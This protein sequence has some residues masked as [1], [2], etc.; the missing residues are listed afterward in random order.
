MPDIQ[1]IPTTQY[2][3]PRI[4]PHL[5]DP[6]LWDAST[7]Y[8]ALAVVQYEGAGYVARYVPPQG[9]APT[10]TEY[11]VRWSDFNAQL[12]Q[13]QQQVT[14]LAASIDSK[15]DDAELQEAVDAINEAM[16]A[17]V[18]AINDEV[19]GI[20]QRMSA[21]SGIVM[22]PAY[23][24][25]DLLYNTYL[26]WKAHEDGIFYGAPGLFALDH[27]ADFTAF[28]PM[29]LK[30]KAVDGVY[31]RAMSCSVLTLACLMGITYE[32]S[33]YGTG[34]EQSIGTDRYIVGGV[35]I[36]TGGSKILDFASKR[37]SNY[38]Q[39]LKSTG[40]ID[41]ASNTLYCEGLAHWLYDAGYLMPVTN[42]EM[43][44]QMQPGDLMFYANA[45]TD[46]AYYHWE[47]IGH[48]DIFMG[49][50]GDKSY[51]VLTSSG[52]TA[53]VN[54][55][56]RSVTTELTTLIKYMARIPAPINGPDGTNLLTTNPGVGTWGGE[57][58]VAHTFPRKLF[59]NDT[60]LP[61][62]GLHTVV[63]KLN[64]YTGNNVRLN[65]YGAHPDDTVNSSQRGVIYLDN[66]GCY[67]GNGCYYCI[68]DERYTWATID[69]NVQGIRVVVNADSAYSVDIAE[70]RFYDKPIQPKAF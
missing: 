50:N 46:D 66:P 25:L 55:A 4:I 23:S 61:G 54:F 68:Y 31:K 63:V 14:A 44:Y 17:S 36:P 28:T 7:Q 15:V 65:I 43:I 45:D 34:Q 8:D 37:A 57:A 49:W 33:R 32:K 6:I 2:I 10:N 52:D 53:P 64:G 58:N 22:A 41:N 38:W 11:W 42:T 12:A 29:N 56:R 60:A 18:D 51:N 1:N 70:V 16:A 67:L 62:T 59:D 35:N 47:N 40:E 3:G 30:M 20:Q 5:W 39:R 26:T 19:V 13:V 48:V 69:T 9:T 21:G 27:D 24:N